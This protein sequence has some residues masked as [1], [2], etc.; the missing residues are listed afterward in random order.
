MRTVYAPHGKS[1]DADC[2]I[3]FSFG[4]RAQGRQ[5]LPGL[6]NQELAGFIADHYAGKPLFLQSE[7]Y[8]ALQ[9]L[10][11]CRAELRIGKPGGDYLDTREV[12]LQ[13]KAFMAAHGCH[14]ALLVGQAHHITRIDAICKKLGLET[15]VPEHLPALWDNASCQWWTRSRLSWGLREPAVMLHHLMRRWV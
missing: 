4:Y 3:A 10:T 5:V 13:A 6:V 14:R 15:I 7:I 11:G 1:E 2:V 8:D 9:D 12:A